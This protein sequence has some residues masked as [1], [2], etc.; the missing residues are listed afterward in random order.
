MKKTLLTILQ[1]VIFL[2]L[3]IYII[4][5]LLHQLDAKQRE[6]LVNAIKSVHLWLLAPIFV[7]GF[8]SHL[9]RALRWKLLL[10]PLNIHPSSVNVTFSVLIGYIA[11]LVLPR[12]GEV[13]KCTVLGR[14]EKMPA[15]KMVGTI[16]AER[17]FDVFCL[18]II[19]VVAFLLQAH[20]IGSYAAELGHRF[21]ENIVK[22]RVVLTIVLAVVIVL[23]VILIM[24]Y[25]R[26]RET[27]FGHF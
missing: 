14:Y 24:M 5:H 6:N 27:K 7:I 25:R 15:H 2:G 21:F 16:V 17:A 23:M 19:T 12:A 10:E 9:F 4:F 18:I 8:L 13:A 11:N 22:N 3:G 26:H 20:I 1:Y